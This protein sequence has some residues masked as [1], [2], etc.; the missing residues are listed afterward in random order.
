MRLNVRN[1]D[2]ISVVVAMITF[3][4]FVTGLI[5]LL[6][7]WYFTA[8]KFPLPQQSLGQ[9][10][11]FTFQSVTL[12]ILGTYRSS[13]HITIFKEGIMMRLFI[14]FRFLHKPIFIPWS[15][16][17]NPSTSNLLMFKGISFKVVTGKIIL[18]EKL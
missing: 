15:A 18:E 1:T 8:K 13:V 9:G 4:L 10:N 11:E 7:G 17:T 6:G 14:L 5:A 3:W 2:S 16:I 12:N